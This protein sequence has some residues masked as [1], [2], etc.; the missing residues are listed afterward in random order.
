MKNAVENFLKKHLK[1]L[2]YR[3]NEICLLKLI[4]LISISNRLFRSVSKIFRSK[5]VDTE[6][7]YDLIF[8]KRTFYSDMLA[9]YVS[10]DFTEEKK[11][12]FDQRIKKAAN[13]KAR[14]VK[15]RLKR[16]Y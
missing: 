4:Y 13:L 10:Y 14:Q 6:G 3:K 12:E 2:R 11:W 15:S 7:L 9:S 5:A 8:N 1:E 16:K